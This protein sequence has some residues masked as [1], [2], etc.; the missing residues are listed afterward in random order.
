LITEEM[1]YRGE[2]TL[3]LSSCLSLG[4]LL[5]NE[6]SNELFSLKHG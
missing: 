3:I 4:K 5:S 2:A 1:G 6:V